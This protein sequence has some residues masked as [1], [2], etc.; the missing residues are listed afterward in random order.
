M[1]RGPLLATGLTVAL[2]ASVLLAGAEAAAL[3]VSAQPDDD[4]EAA[5]CGEGHP[6]GFLVIDNSRADSW[7]E[8]DRTGNSLVGGRGTAGSDHDGGGG[9]IDVRNRDVG[10]DAQS[11][12]PGGWIGHAPSDG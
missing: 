3:P 7:L 9:A 5:F 10:G 8:V 6:V 11:Q 1:I 2:A 4:A 12:P